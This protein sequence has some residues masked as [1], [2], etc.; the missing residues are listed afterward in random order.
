MDKW[1]QRNF[2]TWFC[3]KITEN[4][5]TTGKHLFWSNDD[6]FN[7]LFL[8]TIILVVELN[9]SMIVVAENIY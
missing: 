9:Q 7:M 4:K 5:R 3:M 8:V 1:S 6:V 2:Q